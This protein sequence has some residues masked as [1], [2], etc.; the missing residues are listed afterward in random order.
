MTSCPIFAT[1]PE[2]SRF[3]SGEHVR[4]DTSPM[5]WNVA[6]AVQVDTSHTRIV[7]S[8][9]PE[10]SHSPLREKV[11]ELIQLVCSVRNATGTHWWCGSEAAAEV[12]S[13]T[14]MVG[15]GERVPDASHLPSGENA[16]VRTVAL[17]PLRLDSKTPDATSHSLV[18]PSLEPTASRSPSTEKA[19]DLRSPTDFNVTALVHEAWRS[20]GL[21]DGVLSQ[22]PMVPSAKP[23][24]RRMPT[25]ENATLRTPVLHIRVA[26]EVSNTTSHIRRVPSSDPEAS[27]EPS[28]EK[29]TAFTVPACSE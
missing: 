5:L 18:K 21:L 24:A 23:T 25:G 28:G 15:F 22:I 29:A 17:W 27:S 3:P 16:T 2:T 13:H 1:S 14:R 10:M 9:D 19:M 20:E 7:L 26:T 4:H 12:A 8:H 11:I 6:K